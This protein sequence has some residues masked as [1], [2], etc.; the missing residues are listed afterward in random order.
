M[1]IPFSTLFSQLGKLAGG[2]SEVNTYQGTTVPA[3]VS[4]L[5]SDLPETV[6]DG[7]Q[8]SQTAAQ[9]SATGWAQNL[10]TM[11]TALVNNTVYSD[12]PLLSKTSISQNLQELI[13]Q[14][15]ANGESVQSASV[16]SSVAGTLTAGNGVCVLA[17]TDSNG[18]AAEMLLPE[19]VRV[20]VSRDSTSGAIAGNEQF[21]ATGQAAVSTGPL[22]GLW[23]AGSGATKTFNACNAGANPGQ[24]GQL[25]ANGDFENFTSNTPNNWVIATGTAGTTV[26]KETTFYTG[27]SSLGI[28]GNGSELTSL[29][30]QFGNTAGTTQ[31]LKPATLY[32]F[33][34][35][36]KVSSVPSGGVLALDLV[37]GSTV[38]QSVAGTNNQVSVS[39][40]SLSSSAW[41]P[42]SGVFATPTVLPTTYN[43]RMHLTTALDNTVTLYIDRL[44]LTPMATLYNGGGSVA[45]F[46]GS[47][48][49]M[50]GDLFTATFTNA[51]PTGSFVRFFQRAFNMPQLGLRLPTAGSPTRSDS[52]IS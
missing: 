35:W 52:L 22:S 26:K 6:T 5:N 28:V 24:Q 31:T 18:Y 44:G 46:S 10:S 25:V 32:A 42:F 1:T 36:L 51:H 2:L 47:S 20:A 43:L 40:N 41:M 3:R 19:A 12:N 17:T 16:G 48:S 50:L 8:S 27:A 13:R 45:V 15:L 30:Q 49:F 21:K 14:M 11:A 29:T 38:L 34:C 33:N 9:N 23:P 4:T 37:T 39:L 7:I